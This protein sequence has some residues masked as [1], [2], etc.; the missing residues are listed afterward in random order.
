MPMT[1]E[2]HAQTDLTLHVPGMS[3]AGCVRRIETAIDGLDGITGVS[4]NLATREVH[5]ASNE[6]VL[7]TEVAKAL[8]QAGYAPARG[9]VDLAISAMTCASCVGRVEALLMAQD[10]VF[11]ASVNLATGKARVDTIRGAADVSAI[12]AALTAAGYPAQ[13][14]RADTVPEE[15]KDLA[16]LRQQAL[17][18]AVLTAPVFALEMGG[19]LIPGFHLWVMETLGHRTNWVIQAVLTTLVLAG[20]GRMFFARGVPALLRGAPD[21]N[22]LVALGTS[23]AW[24]FSI[25]ALF[26]PGFLPDGT[27]AVYFEAAAVIATLILIGRYLEARARGRAGEAIGSLMR[28]RPDHV[29]VERGGAVERRAVAEVVT[30]DIVHVRPGERIAVDGRIL[31]GHSFIDESMITGEPVAVEKAAGDMVTGG[32]VNGTGAFRFTATAVGEDTV[33]ARIVGMVNAA[34]TGKLPIQALVDRVTGVFVPVVIAVSV[35]T[36]AVWLL[37]G[38]ASALDLG[39]VAAVSV[40]IVACPCAMGLATPMS[41]MVGTGRAAELGVLFR[42][43]EALQQLRAARVVAFDKTGTLTRGAPVLTRVAT[44]EGW[45]EA[46]VLRLAAAV[47]ARSEHPVAFAVVQGAQARGIAIPEVTAFAARVGQGA[48]ASVDGRFVQVGTARWLG[49]AGALQSDMEAGAARGETAFL[50]A[51]D[52]AVVA[53]LAVADPAKPEAAGVIA[54]LKAQGLHVVMLTGDA[55]ATAEAIAAQMGIDAVMAELRP[56]GKQAAL[57]ALRDAHGTVAFVGDGINDAPALAEADVGIALG[58]GTDVAIEAADVVLMSGDMR[59]VTRARGISGAVMRNIRQNLFWAFAYN[60]A[61]IPV[62]AG[63]LYPLTGTLLSPMLAAGAMA[64]SSVFVV[65]NALRL[66]R[67]APDAPRAAP[68]QARLVA[69]VTA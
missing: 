3:C 64:L 43:G 24:L 58:T 53:A 12:A 21:M 7:A 42:K 22:A 51:V 29:E 8:D 56:D 6:G 48:E 27:R 16:R 20:P 54:G 55:R 30:G 4:A 47:E 23:A 60:T 18:A 38:S 49:G 46:A 2:C 25:V 67:F 32:T 9:S 61:L 26:L 62:A 45:S 13:V 63:V 68:E 5:I 19:H 34:Q 17:L 69:E 15:G 11:G 39:L 14:A 59:G 28:L 66:R 31:D 1:K 35:L 41:I 57:Q 40:L 65:V 52:G 10:G 50:V 44:V 36:V 33:L 37:V